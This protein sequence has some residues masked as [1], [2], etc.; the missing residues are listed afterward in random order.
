VVNISQFSWLIN[1]STF[2]FLAIKHNVF[3]Q[4]FLAIQEMILNGDFSFK[5]IVNDVENTANP[6]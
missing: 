5:I 4:I 6:E 2:F 3:L 1:Q